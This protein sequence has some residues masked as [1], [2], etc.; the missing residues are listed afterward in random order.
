[1]GVP[2]SD[3]KNVRWVGNASVSCFDLDENGKV[4]IVYTDKRDHLGRLA[5]EFGKKV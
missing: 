3:L 1:M 4:S 5:T 2:A